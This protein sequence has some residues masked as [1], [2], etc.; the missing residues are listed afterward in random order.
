MQQAA[1]L[2]GVEVGQ[3]VPPGGRKWLAVGAA[4]GPLFR[5]RPERLGCACCRRLTPPLLPPNLPCPC[6]LPLP[7]PRLPSSLLPPQGS[8]MLTRQRDQPGIVG[9]VGMLLAADKV[10]INYMTVR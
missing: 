2:V 8:I 9:G 5:V 3:R 7:L 1:A 10:N 4:A 6:P